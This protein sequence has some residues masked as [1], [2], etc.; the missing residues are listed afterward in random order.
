VGNPVTPALGRLTRRIISS[1]PAWV[2]YRDHI[3]KQKRKEGREG[4]SLSYSNFKL[5]ESNQISYGSEYREEL[6]MTC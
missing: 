2:T 5:A 6:M 1:R 3:K 4:R